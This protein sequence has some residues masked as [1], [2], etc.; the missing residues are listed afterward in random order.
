MTPA[1]QRLVDAFW[2]IG[3]D[4][5]ADAEQF[6]ILVAGEEAADAAGEPLDSPRRPSHINPPD[7]DDA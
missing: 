3:V 1:E 7:E 6:A 5:T 2:A 4:I